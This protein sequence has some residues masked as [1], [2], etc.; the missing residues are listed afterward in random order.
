MSDKKKEKREKG[1]WWNGLKA[2]FSK[3]VW[4][5]G[6]TLGKQTVA[7]I[8]VTVILGIIIALLDIGI[9]FGVDFLVKL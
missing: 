4:L 7:V 5:D 3:I 6:K 2:E 8:I 9:Q 1:S